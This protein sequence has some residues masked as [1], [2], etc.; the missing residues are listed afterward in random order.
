MRPKVREVVKCPK[1]WARGYIKNQG[2]PKRCP[3]CQGKKFI[4]KTEKEQPVKE[5]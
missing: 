1:C 5:D 3:V 2:E 4:N